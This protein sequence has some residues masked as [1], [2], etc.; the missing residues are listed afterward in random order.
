LGKTGQKYAL[1]NVINADGKKN[2]DAV[3][4]LGYTY[5]DAKVAETVIIK[6]AVQNSIKEASKQQVSEVV[7]QLKQDANLREIREGMLAAFQKGRAEM[8]KKVI[9]IDKSDNILTYD[10]DEFKASVK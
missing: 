4:L 1:L 6:N 8:I 5:S 9:I 3:N 2:P 7:I 10:V